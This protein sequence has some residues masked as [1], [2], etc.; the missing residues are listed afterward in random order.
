MSVKLREGAQ[1]RCNMSVRSLFCFLT[2]VQRGPFELFQP[3]WL[4]CDETI[5]PLRV[6]MIICLGIKQNN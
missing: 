1:F 2:S 4:H 6:I 3:F 5:S